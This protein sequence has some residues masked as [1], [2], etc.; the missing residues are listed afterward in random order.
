VAYKARNDIEREKE[1]K[2]YVFEGKLL[3]GVFGTWFP[4]AT[5][6]NEVDYIITVLE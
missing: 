4:D 5:P 1:I 3:T 2:D 6:R